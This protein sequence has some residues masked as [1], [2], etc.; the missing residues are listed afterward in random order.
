M[1]GFTIWHNPKCVTSRFAL[2]ALREAGIDPVVRDYQKDPPSVAEL[3]DALSRL[4]MPPRGLLRR[5]N[6]P[7]DDLGLGDQSLSDDALIAAMAA[8]PAL[9]QRPVVFAPHTARLCR[10]KEAVFDLLAVVGAGR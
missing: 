4:G 7:Y 10:P 9:I 5:Q 2:A 6:T 3:R 1:S 8:H